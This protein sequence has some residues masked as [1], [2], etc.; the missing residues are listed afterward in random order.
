MWRGQW[1]RR[2]AWSKGMAVVSEPEAPHLASCVTRLGGLVGNNCRVRT[3]GGRG[4]KDLPMQDEEEITELVESVSF[5]I[6]VTETT[7]LR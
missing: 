1:G 2:Q 4:A 3:L 6:I 7:E 5:F